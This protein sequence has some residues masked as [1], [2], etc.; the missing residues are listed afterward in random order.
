[1]LLI[2]QKGNTEGK[3]ERKRFIF[4]CKM[5]YLKIKYPAKNSEGESGHSAIRGFTRAFLVKEKH[6]I[7]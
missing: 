1:M 4:R 6:L 2:T 7:S 5:S 3:K